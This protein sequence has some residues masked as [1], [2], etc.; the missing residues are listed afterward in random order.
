MLKV[1][2]GERSLPALGVGTYALDKSAASADALRFAVD[3]G[4]EVI[5]CATY[6]HNEDFIG[7]VLKPVRDRVFLVGKVLP[8]EAS[9]TGTRRAYPQLGSVQRRSARAA[10]TGGGGGMRRLGNSL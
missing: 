5:D 7:E 8:S 1:T 2:L 4:L 10:F 6:Y 9:Y 3:A